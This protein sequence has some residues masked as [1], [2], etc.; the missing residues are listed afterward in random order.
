MEEIKIYRKK[1]APDNLHLLNN[2]YLRSHIEQIIEY[3]NPIEEFLEEAVQ[4]IYPNF[5]R[6][7][8]Q[9]GWG[10]VLKKYFRIESEMKNKSDVNVFALGS[11][12][13]IS[14]FYKESKILEKTI[15]VM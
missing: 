2:S 1:F 8:I 3:N 11:I 10:W 6:E 12:M 5:S 9:K 14:V 13:N 7:K 15:E 4:I